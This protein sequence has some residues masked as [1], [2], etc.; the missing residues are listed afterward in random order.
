MYWLYFTYSVEPTE[1]NTTYQYQADY[2]DKEINFCFD[3]DF[4]LT[5][6]ENE[7][8]VLKVYSFETIEEEEIDIRIDETELEN[9]EPINDE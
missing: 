5:R 9:C 4:N 1:P 3:Q 6:I 8:A 2:N 7:V